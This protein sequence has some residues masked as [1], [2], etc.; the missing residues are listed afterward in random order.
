[1]ESQLDE[2]ITMQRHGSL[3]C[4]CLSFLFITDI[5]R[6]HIKI[7]S[8]KIDPR[9]DEDQDHIWTRCHVIVRD[10]W[11]VSACLIKC[12]LKFEYECIEND[13]GR[14]SKFFEPPFE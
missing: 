12:Y 11:G 2:K 10:V 1:M 8:H 9:C 5:I 3:M 14:T 4:L 7:N 13:S 6:F